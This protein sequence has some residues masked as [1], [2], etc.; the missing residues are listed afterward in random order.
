MINGLSGMFGWY[1]G[2]RMRGQSF[3][4]VA[5]VSLAIGPMFVASVTPVFAQATRT[6]VSGVGDDANP[7][8]RTAPCKTFAGAISKTATN[9]EINVIDPGGFGA[10]SIT[11]SITIDGYGPMSSILAAG[12]NGVIINTTDAN[13]TVTLRNLSINGATS[14]LN[15]I[16]ILSAKSVIV[17]NLEIFG[18]RSGTGRGISDERTAAN[19]VL[20]VINTTF[21][22]NLGAGIYANG[23]I[24][25]Q[26]NNV[27]INRNGLGLIVS[28]GG[29]M[30]VRD[31]AI[32]NNTATFASGAA[33]YG[34][35]LG[36]N[37]RVD[38][39]NTLVS[40]NTIGIS[41]QQGASARLSNTTV[42]DNLGPGLEAAGGGTFTTFSNNSIGQNGTGNDFPG[43]TTVINRK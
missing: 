12:T 41:S 24:V 30:A 16:R 29:Q 42:V 37:A 15:G 18:F 28:G 31:S 8:S 10:V 19:G 36:S 38:F 7:C 2:R 32:S 13:A 43:G 5:V 9:G 39:E 34:V 23:P 4:W 35:F 25:G 33:G 27:R 11:K 40:G 26:A 1:R 17:E 3:T 21:T 22:D 20:T 6:W 14:G